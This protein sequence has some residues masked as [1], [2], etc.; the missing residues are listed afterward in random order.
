MLL[1][2]TGYL[3]KRNDTEG[4]GAKYTAMHVDR[5]A[6][7]AAQLLAGKGFGPVDVRAVQNMIHCTGVNANP[8]A[9][10]FQSEL[11][12]ILGCAL[13]TADLLGQ[14]AADDYIEKLP[15]LYEE[16][17]EAA[18]YAR[19]HSQFI[20]HFD[21][22]EDLMRKT[23]LF[24]ENIVQAKLA[25]EFGGLCR[26]LNDPYPYGPNDYLDR[27]RANIQ[28]LKSRLAAPVAGAQGPRA[29]G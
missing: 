17:A 28:R 1:H 15:I 29:A 8:D 20:T 7:F 13:G 26:F 5:S 18:P 9:I 24:W 11:E 21:S 10:T 25:N 3:K 19:Q 14:M 12:R 22:A 6:D 4:T 2:D 16:L 27:I 23:P